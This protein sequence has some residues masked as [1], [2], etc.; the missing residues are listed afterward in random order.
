MEEAEDGLLHGGERIGPMNSLLSVRSCMT[1][2]LPLPIMI[3]WANGLC[4][5]N[6]RLSL[7]A[8]EAGAAQS[9]TSL[10]W[11]LPMLC[12]PYTPRQRVCSLYLY[13][14]KWPHN[15]WG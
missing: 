4:Y 15:V 2:L 12:C 5:G 11:S 1:A 8:E 9:D 3:G 7:V 10:A 6:Y 13:S 14:D